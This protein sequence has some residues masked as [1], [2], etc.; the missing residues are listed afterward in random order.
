MLLADADD[1]PPPELTLENMKEEVATL[2]NLSKGGKS[3]LGVP[4]SNHT[5]FW[6]CYT[7]TLVAQEKDSVPL[8]RSVFSSCGCRVDIV[9]RSEND[10][11]VFGIVQTASKKPQR[12]S[13]IRDKLRMF[14]EEH[15]VRQVEEHGIRQAS[16]P[17]RISVYKVGS[18][19]S[20]YVVLNHAGNVSPHAWRSQVSN[21]NYHETFN[22]ERDFSIWLSYYSRITNIMNTSKLGE[23]LVEAAKLISE[24]GDDVTM[25]EVMRLFPELISTAGTLEKGASL[26][27]THRLQP[28]KRKR[29]TRDEFMRMFHRENGNLK[30]YSFVETYAFKAI[31]TI[32][33]L[34][35]MRD[36]PK[37]IA[38]LQSLPN[39]HTADEAVS[40]F[41]RCS[42][43]RSSVAFRVSRLRDTIL[44][45][46]CAKDSA[47]VSFRMLNDFE[48]VRFEHFLNR[49]FSS[50]QPLRSTLSSEIPHTT[51]PFL[52]G[53]HGEPN[54]SEPLLLSEMSSL[55]V[56][57]FHQK[58]QNA[59]DPVA[60]L[61]RN[62]VKSSRCETFPLKTR[63]G[64]SSLLME[65]VNK[66]R[67]TRELG[68]DGNSELLYRIQ[69][70]HQTTLVLLSGVKYPGTGFHSD[71]TRAINIGFS[72]NECPWEQPI[73][74]WT[75]INPSYINDVNDVLKSMGYGPLNT[76]ERITPP[77][78]REL[79]SRAGCD[80]K[81][82]SK[83]VLLEQKS[84]YLVSVPSGWVH[85]VH[86]FT[87]CLK[88]AW[89][90]LIVSEL[91][92]YVDTWKRLITAGSVHING[93]ST[94][95]FPV[96]Q[97]IVT[98]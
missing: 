34:T 92:D 97:R 13:F 12:P 17:Y 45:W 52:L 79:Q 23:K 39:I 94:G 30:P 60:S 69:N 72:L 47:A 9:I 57:V 70:L 27:G 81:G 11:Y 90:A 54:I 32:F 33:D 7:Y 26:L 50:P 98:Q 55:D 38:S 4:N 36:V 96:L 35:D 65:L 53:K 31:A 43:C 18:P 56:A 19:F 2:L 80:E 78:S 15:G 51:G 62:L 1:A 46:L 37:L 41:E 89:D 58:H 25:P 84:G 61:L 14:L 20:L 40:D 49:G 91:P 83:V 76:G 85:C 22:L 71:H 5:G 6:Y 68:Y 93:D 87:A 67:E 42:L 28:E 8:P 88:V 24:N 66:C 10:G 48:L 29:K 74:L 16:S 82:L 3:V 63:P 95:Y 64:T 77:V 73:A 59:S 86:N 75:L 21:A 44:C